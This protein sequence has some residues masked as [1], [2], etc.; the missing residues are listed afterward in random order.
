MRLA[1]SVLFAARAGSCSSR[2]RSRRSSPTRAHVRSRR[3]DRR[4]RP[5]AGR[6]RGPPSPRLRRVASGIARH[7]EAVRV[8][9]RTIDPNKGCETLLRHFLRYARGGRSAV[10]LVMAGPEN[11]PMPDHPMVRRLGFV[12]GDRE[13]DAS[14][15]RRAPRRALGLREPEPRAAGGVESSACRRSSTDIVPC[16]RGRRGART[17]RSTTGISTSSRAGSYCSSGP[18]R[19]GAAARSAGARVRDQRVPLAARD[20]EGR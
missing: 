13:G 15:E 12:G 5:R 18:S 10:P 14:V 1:R 11:M 7:R 6:A 9:S 3:R 19:R 17:A 20:S 2:L 4:I 16:S 8:V